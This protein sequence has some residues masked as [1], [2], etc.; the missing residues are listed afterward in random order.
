MSQTTN[1]SNQAIQA[2]HDSY[3]SEQNQFDQDHCER[4]D[5]LDIHL[6]YFVKSMYLTLIIPPSSARP[7]WFNT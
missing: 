7:S 6:K 5:K 4:D 1:E 3:Q 2:L